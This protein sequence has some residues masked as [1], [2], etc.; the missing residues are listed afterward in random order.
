MINRLLSKAFYAI[1][2]TVLIQLLLCLPGSSI[3]SGGFF[4]IPQLDKI[5]HIILFGTFTGLWCYYYFLKGKPA[6]KLKTIFFIIYL[7]A[8]ANGIILEFIQR[9]YIPNRSFDQGDIIADIIAS[10]IAY[11]ICN[12]KLLKTMD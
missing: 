11:G 5:A 8:A 6:G 4:N 7:L 10:S 1:A 9:D 12:I 3:P 2:W